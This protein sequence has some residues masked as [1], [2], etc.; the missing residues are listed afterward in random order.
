MRKSLKHFVLLI[1][2]HS[3][4]VCHHQEQLSPKRTWLHS[5]LTSLQQPPSLKDPRNRYSQSHCRKIF[6]ALRNGEKSYEPTTKK[7]SFAARVRVNNL[8]LSGSRNPR[9]TSFVVL[10]LMK[11]GT[12]K[13]SSEKS[14]LRN[15]ES[16]LDPS[17]KRSIAK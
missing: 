4:P 17:L 11:E 12:K 8:R 16:S 2:F 1:T 5:R 3:I 14:N 7:K 10:S 13:I 9:S 15:F 6:E